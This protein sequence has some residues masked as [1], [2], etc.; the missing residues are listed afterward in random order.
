MNEKQSGEKSE[1]LEVLCVCIHPDLVCQA[2][3]MPGKT[4]NTMSTFLLLQLINCLK[5]ASILRYLDLNF[6]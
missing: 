5:V 2:M 1:V 6:S 3:T 4:F